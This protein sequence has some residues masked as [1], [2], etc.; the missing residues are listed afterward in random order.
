MAEH[1][2]RMGRNMMTLKWKQPKEI[3]IT[4]IAVIYATF[5]KK[6]CNK[7]F[8]GAMYEMFMSNPIQ[9]VLRGCHYMDV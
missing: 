8:L 4:L 2:Q 1:Q 7:S 3:C 9:L 5:S 6:R